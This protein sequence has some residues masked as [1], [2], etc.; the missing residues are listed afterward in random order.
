MYQSVNPCHHKSPVKLWR[1]GFPLQLDYCFVLLT[2]KDFNKF[3][4]AL[5]KVACCA[6]HWLL[7]VIDTRSLWDR[8]PP[9]LSV[10]SDAYLSPNYQSY[11][12]AVYFLRLCDIILRKDWYKYFYIIHHH[13]FVICHITHF[14][15]L[16]VTRGAEQEAN[17]HDSLWSG[18]YHSLFC[19]VSASW[20]PCAER[21]ST[22][23]TTCIASETWPHIHYGDWILFKWRL[24]KTTETETHCFLLLKEE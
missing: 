2:I 8:D 23:F 21:V 4:L 10:A 9:L 14:N 12:V 17:I 7:H 24:F 20:K 5:N 11:F 19:I 1:L 6:L 3:W 18:L 16:T 22:L 13:S 15:T